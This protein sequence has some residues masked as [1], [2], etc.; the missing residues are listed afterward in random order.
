MTTLKWSIVAVL[1]AMHGVA[2]ARPIELA[3]PPNLPVV[4]FDG[5]K[6][7]GF[8][9]ELSDQALRQA[10]FV[11][12]YQ[13]LPFARLYA[14]LAAKQIDGALSV[15][16]TPERA[17]TA[18]F[19]I[20]LVTEYSILIAPKGRTFPFQRPVDL[21]GK[22]IA[23][24][25]GF[26]YP[27]IDGT[28]GVTLQPNAERANNLRLTALGRVDAAIVGSIT[29]LFQARELNI[30]DQIEALPTAIAG[31]ELGIA[32]NSDR[33]TDADLE[34]LNA[35]LRAVLASPSFAAALD[36]AGVTGL[37]RSFEVL[38]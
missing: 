8:F 30:A 9:G 22:T 12:S 1:L 32:L 21:A 38:R 2:V 34:R 35:A 26:T 17:R 5:G 19:S 28:P 24:Q 14:Q 20:P 36:R 31:I 27:G 10:G 18:R 25:T 11:P 15:L 16:A 7:V 23:T 29:G 37:V 4:G 3:V 33:F 13:P 6:A